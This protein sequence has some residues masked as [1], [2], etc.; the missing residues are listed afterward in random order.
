MAQTPKAHSQS[1]ADFF[2][3]SANGLG[4]WQTMNAHLSGVASLAGGFADAFNMRADAELSG[5][6]H[7]IGKYGWSFQERLH[8]REHGL[9]HWSPGAW[10]A[11]T[12]F[13]SV[14]VALAIQGHHV[15]LQKNDK[16][17][18]LELDPTSLAKN[19]PLKLRLS[20]TDIALLLNL[21]GADGL[22]PA[23]RSLPNRVPFPETASAMLDVRMLFSA[24]VDA[25][26]LDT[27]EHMRQ[28]TAKPPRPAGKTLE[29][30]RAFDK[31]SEFIERLQKSKASSEA[32]KQ[33]RAD[34]WKACV[35][36]GS[37]DHRL[38]TLSAPT[39]AGKTL[40]MLGFALQQAIKR[41]LRRVV[42][43]VPYL[44]IIDQTARTYRELLEPVFGEGYIIEHHSMAMM[45]RETERAG[46]DRDSEDATRRREK[47]LAENW[48]APIV[49]TTSV[50]FLESLFSNRPSAARKLH[51]LAQSV[52]LFDEVQTLP[53]HLA[54][55][56]LKALSRLT[57]PQYGAS[58]VF[59]TATQPAFEHLHAHVRETENSGWQP[60]EVV[61]P[62]LDLFNRVRRTHV[63][64]PQLDKPMA[65][66]D[67]AEV[68]A[69]QERTLCIV[70]LKRHALHLATCL[71]EMGVSDI[72]HLSTSMCPAHRRKAID[73]I[74]HCLDRKNPKDCRLIATQCV[75]AGVDLD[76]PTA[77]RAFCP[78]DAVAQAAGR[79]NRN[80]HGEMG[81]VTVFVPEE[82]VY[83]P[84]G[85]YQQAAAITRMLLKERGPD[86]MDIHDPAL[87]A[88]YFRRLYDLTRPEA[89]SDE[90][91][92]AIRRQDYPEVSRLYRLIDMDTI[93]VLV[94]YVNDQYSYD[95][96]ADEVRATGLRGDWIRRAR[97]LT[98]N[99]FRPKTGDAVTRYLEVIRIGQKETSEDW[100]IYWEPR[101]Y[102][103]RFG[104]CPPEETGFYGA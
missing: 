5:I 48:D 89:M 56:T 19:H 68:I 65:W 101:H 70:N 66:K 32:V 35:E 43:V 52:I 46:I 80:G 1:P 20:E 33:V 24:L 14:N 36:A 25:D 104:L 16:P 93:N 102:H 55:P 51:R 13:F 96:L 18:L 8:G 57:E 49:I 84:G 98:I 82:E 53:L 42:I 86:N 22:A 76:F 103:P 39:G 61:S 26:F 40:A 30:Q 54:V 41:N 74:N 15:G 4:H 34:L 50:Q 58:V 21:L 95:A 11:L 64:W 23:P 59:S 100:F 91:R 73:E 69:K 3:H 81:I 72:W 79:C 10:I 67:L 47:L 60:T 28:G 44:S 99:L 94:P 27:E 83:P 78:L 71:E 85:G 38:W 29:P 63:E 45:R 92:G 62:Q 87:F 75:E 31:L 6:L 12:K 9:D 90:L 77:Y 97:P 37:L 88:L 17:S 2:A 7:D